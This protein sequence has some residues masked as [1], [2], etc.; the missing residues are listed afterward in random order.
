MKA[1]LNSTH[2]GAYFTIPEGLL[3]IMDM[4][5]SAYIKLTT[6]KTVVSGYAYM[7]FNEEGGV[8]VE[9]LINTVATIIFPLSLS[10]LLPVF[11]YLTV[12]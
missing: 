6:G 3:S 11:L 5:S 9:M 8:F 7:P 4:V 1:D 2:Y 10:L 12:L